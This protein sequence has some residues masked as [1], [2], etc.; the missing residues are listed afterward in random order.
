MKTNRQGAF[1]KQRGIRAG[2]TLVE[3]MIA[4]IILAIMALGG[5]SYL[6]QSR[7][8]LA[9]QRNKRAALEVGNARLEEIR[10]T[11]YAMLTSLF[12]TDY[13]LHYLRKVG[14]AWQASSA[15]PGETASI[16]G[17]L[18][19]QATTVQYQ[20]VDGGASS[21]DCLGVIVKT[22]YRLGSSDRVKLQT[23]YAP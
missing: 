7:A 16:N 22:A 6:Y 5:A 1:Q 3:T 13:N 14:G 20:D 17:S 12:A 8:S 11:S 23:I 4:C 21:Y 10:A 18:L 19:P 15:D 2:T 9:M